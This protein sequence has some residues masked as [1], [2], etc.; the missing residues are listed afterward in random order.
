MAQKTD[1]DSEGIVTCKVYADGA[2]IDSLLQ[3]VS[4][5]IHKEVN[6]ISKA[7]IVLAAGRVA[8]AGVEE[9]EEEALSPGKGISVTVSY[10]TGSES[11]I[12]EGI[13]TAYSFEIEENASFLRIEYSDPVWATTL[14][15]K[16]RLFKEVTDTDA[17][18]AILNEYSSLSFTVEDSSSEH[19][20]LVQYYATDWDFIRCR[21]D[22]NGWVLLS[23][24]TALSVAV[25]NVNSSP[26]LEV[27]WGENLLEFSGT[28]YA[29]PQ[30][31]GVTA[32][33][34]DAA[35][36]SLITGT[37]SV[38]AVNKQGEEYPGSLYAFSD[39]NQVI[40][41]T[42]CVPDSDT[43]QNW[44]DARYLRNA[45]SR[46]RGEVRFQ[47]NAKAL[48]G[49]LI[50]ITGVG[51]RFNGDLYAGMVLHEI[52]EG[53]WTTTV[54]IGLPAEENRSYGDVMAPPA[55]GLLPGIYGLYI[56]TV[57]HLPEDPLGEYRIEIAF[58]L[59]GVDSNTVRARLV[60]PWA[61]S[62]YGT[63]FL[64]DVGDEVVIEFFNGDPSFPVILGSM[65]GSKNVPPYAFTEDNNVWGIKI[66]SG[67]KME[68]QEEE[69]SITLE[70]PK[71]N[72]FCLTDDQEKIFLS[73]QH[74]NKIEMK[75]E[76]IVLDSVG[77]ISLKAQGDITLE[78]G[79]A[80]KGE[81][82][83]DMTWEGMNIN[84]TAGMAFVAKGSTKA[85]LTATGQTVIKGAMVAI[86]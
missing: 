54:G 71:G 59:L 14:V 25:P 75:S 63:C 6:R 52:E 17:L 40:L 1:N 37:A 42:A 82:G 20:E 77:S 55:S 35:T 81:A 11:A 41:Q 85:E 86:N 51:K 47:G 66:R 24:G 21:A 76:G 33:A 68:F 50:K 67:M 58:S 22:A 48:P 3:L 61:S 84:A 56:G 46:I 28:L 72:I 69:S 9:G 29:A 80:L 34:W 7:W 64:P 16:N 13:I 36:H 15:R 38:P 4:V 83:T 70:T 23:E 74:G 5:R 19:A 79:T 27:M 49:S 45:L 8:S 53:N 65:Y 43:L 12:Y 57:T 10:G 30:R 44:A 26:V 2:E 60:Q 62:G 39:K 31:A 32:T 78:A 18:S 73:D